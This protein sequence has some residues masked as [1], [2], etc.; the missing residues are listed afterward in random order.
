METRISAINHASEEYLCAQSQENEGLREKL[1]TMAWR[2]GRLAVSPFL[3]KSLTDNPEDYHPVRYAEVAPDISYKIECETGEYPVHIYNRDCLGDR[4]DNPDIYLHM[5]LMVRPD[6]GFV[7]P[8]IK[9]LE[10]LARE[11]ERGLVVIGAPSSHGKAMRPTELM[12][13]NLHS[14]VEDTHT[15]IDEVAL[16]ERV[17][18]T[19]MIHTGASLGGYL[20]L[21]FADQAIA[22]GREKFGLQPHIVELSLPVAPAGWSLNNKRRVKAGYQFLVLEPA[23]VV[24]KVSRMSKDER[25]GY[26]KSLIETVPFKEALPGVLKLGKNFLFDGDLEETIQRLPRD[27]RVTATAFDGDYITLPYLLKQHLNQE[28]FPNSKVHV[29]DGRHLSLDSNRKIFQGVIE[30]EINNLYDESTEAKV[31]NSSF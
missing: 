23:H 7:A 15:A 1:E 2:V 14:I 22:E 10:D 18:L 13:L 9:N 4:S 8:M 3:Q 11:Q 19:K 30:P 20:S 21:V 12:R 29:I 5:S 16:A 24:E 17:E 26:V 28:D 27:Y 31:V 6:Q 25:D